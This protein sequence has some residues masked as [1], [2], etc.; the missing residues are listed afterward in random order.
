MGYLCAMT[1]VNEKALSFGFI[2]GTASLAFVVSQ[3][4]VSIVNIALPQIAGSFSAGMI[5]T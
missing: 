5:L 4:D 1:Q 3:L 2:V